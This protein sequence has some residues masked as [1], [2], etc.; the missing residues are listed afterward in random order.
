[1]KHVVLVLAQANMMNYCYLQSFDTDVQ[2]C[3]EVLQS[4]ISVTGD[5]TDGRKSRDLSQL[6]VQ[7]PSLIFR[8]QVGLIQHQETPVCGKC[9][10]K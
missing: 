10:Q 6:L 4:F 1:M 3:E 9:Y 7:R 2:Q 5:E 8:Q